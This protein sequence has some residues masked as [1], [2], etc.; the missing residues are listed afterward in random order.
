M[1]LVG[2]TFKTYSSAKLVKYSI[3]IRIVFDSDTGNICSMELC[4]GGGK[5]LE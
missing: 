5:K 1:V 4:T 3:L 2:S